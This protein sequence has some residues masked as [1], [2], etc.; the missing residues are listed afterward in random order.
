MENILLNIVLEFFYDSRFYAPLS[1][2]NALHLFYTI[3]KSLF[4]MWFRRQ[5]DDELHP[6]FPSQ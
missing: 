6:S 3:F 5:E 4:V 2:V 1:V